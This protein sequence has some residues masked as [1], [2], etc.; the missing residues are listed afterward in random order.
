MNEVVV[1]GYGSQV[2]K[3]LTS[4]IASVKGEDIARVP[5][6]NLD[7]AIQGKVAG[8]QVVQN[9]GAPGDETYIRIR[10]NGSLFGG[11]RPLY[12]IDGVPMNNIPAGVSPLGGDGQRITATNDINPNDI[13]SIDILKD[14]AATAIYG[15]RAAAGVVLITTKKGKEGKARFNINAYTGV[16]EI[17]NRLILLNGDQYVDLITQSRVSSRPTFIITWVVR[18]KWLSG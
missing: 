3:N 5:V 6:T 7:A 9:S 11:N 1:V 4:S 14:A 15:S 12:V 17:T 2:R 18:I 8:V 10:G 16:A 13:E